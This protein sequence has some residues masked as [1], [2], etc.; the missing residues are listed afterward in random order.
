MIAFVTFVQ[1]EDFSLLRKCVWSI[2]ITMRK[3]GVPYRIYAIV[4]GEEKPE[5]SN[6]E[7]E[8]NIVNTDFDRGKGPSLYGQ[9]CVVGEIKTF[10]AILKDQ[11]DT[12]AFV[13][14]DADVLLNDT[15]WLKAMLT[16]N[17]KLLGHATLINDH[18]N[19]NKHYHYAF[20]PAYVLE[21]SQ[22]NLIPDDSESLFDI[23]NDIDESLDGQLSKPIKGRTPWLD[24]Q[25]ISLLIHYYW[26]EYHD[27]VIYVP[28]SI[29][30]NYGVIAWWRWDLGEDDDIDR[31][32]GFD[33]IDCGR[34]PKRSRH[35]GDVDDKMNMIADELGLIIPPTKSDDI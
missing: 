35:E 2:Q 1:K 16:G 8:V 29:G 6:A 4:D 19:P 27:A 20:G 24:D 5:W 10:K 32:A 12:K 33:F 17:A 25:C 7:P 23:L 18:E 11:P 15:K 9:E 34:T 26:K 3:T 13:N 21:A 28:H 30:D 31:F 22:F 14:I